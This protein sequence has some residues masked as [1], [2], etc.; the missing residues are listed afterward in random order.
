MK[1]AYEFYQV[2]GKRFTTH[3]LKLAQ[4][5]CENLRPESRWEMAKQA[6]GAL[7]ELQLQHLEHNAI[8]IMEAERVNLLHAVEWAHHSQEWSAVCQLADEL[9]IFFNIRSY[10]VDWVGIAEL[11][12]TSAAFVTDPKLEA[13][14][15]NNMSVVCRQ[16]ERLSDA[17]AYGQHSLTLCRQHGYRYN[18]GL[19]HG[20]LGGVFFAQKELSTSLEHYKAAL[21]IF[22]ELDD[23]Y[24]QAQS[25]LGVGITLAQ[26]RHLPESVS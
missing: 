3:Y 6:F 23:R 8:A 4:E 7:S 16:L 14:A 5:V 10:W 22:E 13:E 12:V 9:A 24:G 2:S 18:E 15:M 25:L 26:Q 20:N 11:A 21:Q 19:A 1:H 17:A